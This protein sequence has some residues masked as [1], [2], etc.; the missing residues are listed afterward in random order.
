MW[1]GHWR[2]RPCCSRRHQIDQKARKIWVAHREVDGSNPDAT[3]AVLPRIP[4]CTSSKELMSCFGFP[5]LAFFGFTR[6]V[7][8]ELV[9]CTSFR[10]KRWHKPTPTLD[11][12]ES[13]APYTGVECIGSVDGIICFRSETYRASSLKWKGHAS[14]SRGLR[15]K[16]L[17]APFGIGGAPPQLTCS[18]ASVPG[19]RDHLPSEQR[20][21]DTL[22]QVWACDCL[23][24]SQEDAQERNNTLENLGDWPF[25]AAAQPAWLVDSRVGAA[26]IG[27]VVCG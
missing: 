20:H 4:V 13:P 7:L 19:Q 22:L 9:S 10:P 11:S 14:G 1:P 18:T 27:F 23:K 3:A 2:G 6:G 12:P 25:P 8:V 15:F 26:A 21:P 16:A 17:K 24:P 5:K